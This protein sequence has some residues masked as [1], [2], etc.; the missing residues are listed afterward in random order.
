ML[1]GNKQLRVAQGLLEGPALVREMQNFR[2]RFTANANDTYGS[3][4]EGSHDD[5]VLAVAVA[6][7]YAV[8]YVPFRGFSIL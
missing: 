4:R 8:H 1:M 5:L 2:Y 6:T 3:W 7:W